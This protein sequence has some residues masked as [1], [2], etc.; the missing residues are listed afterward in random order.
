MKSLLLA[1][2]PLGGVAGL[3]SIKKDVLIV[4]GGSSGIYT[5]IS[6]M[7]AGKDVVIIEK[8]N[9]IGSHA[10]TYYDPISKTPRNVGVQSLANVSV[11]LDYLARLNITT[12][13]YT[14]FNA[15]KT[16]NVDFTTGLEVKN[17]TAANSSVTLA[18]LERYRSIIQEKYA[19][20]EDGFFL[21]DPVPDELLTPFTEFA[22]KHGIDA[23][24]PF[25][26]KIIQPVELW[27]Q[28]TLYV[29]KY[30]GIQSID[31]YLNPD[32]S[33]VPRDVSDIYT[34]AAKVLGSRVLLNSSVESVKRRH[35]GV[36]VV[37]KTPT[38]KICYEVDRI[39]MA[40]PQLIQ[41]FA[42][43]DLSPSEAA[44]FSKFQTK[45]VHI[46]ITRN[47][48]WNNVSISGVGPASTFT[49][50]RLPGIVKSAPTGFSDSSYY[51]Y[52]CFL[53]DASIQYAQNLYRSQIKHLVANGI[54]PESKNE[55]V[56]WFDH[57]QYMNH[58]SNNDVKNGFYAKL[59]SLQGKSRTYY[60]GA[61]LSGQDSTY[62]WR[63]CKVLLPK[64]LA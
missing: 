3:Q 57:N 43:W 46:G 38:G 52:I 30:Y 26:S 56:E 22:S 18:A 7:D 12:G 9:F 48:E 14:T 41:N 62:I 53:G 31:A 60:V 61:A 33:L 47:P 32:G 10:N 28:S 40:A 6:L 2:L 44:L 17:F 24:V 42:G 11:T 58:V 25:V 35:D 54:L 37:V 1:F 13:P 4:G 49:T 27:N 55:I 29:I 63:A 36:S 23:V 59:N 19:Y 15:P 50:P 51:S 34:S 5:G 21:P 20:L 45:T 8:A 39:V 64:L 16:L